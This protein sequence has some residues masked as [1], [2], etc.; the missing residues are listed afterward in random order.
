[1]GLEFQQELFGT[2]VSFFKLHFW[3]E[4]LGVLLSLGLVLTFKLLDTNMDCVA[5]LPI[6]TSTSCL[7]CFS[8]ALHIVGLS[9]WSKH[10]TWAVVCCHQICIC[11]ATTWFSLRQ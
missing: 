11:T 8:C 2:L 1:M 5:G 6:T 3:V 10:M 4:V 9:R 7:Q